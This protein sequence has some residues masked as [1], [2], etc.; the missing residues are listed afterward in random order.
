MLKQLVCGL[1]VM[2]LSGAVGLGASQ[3]ASS[4][5]RDPNAPG[6]LNLSK[7][8]P[9]GMEGPDEFERGFIADSALKRLEQVRGF[10]NSFRQLTDD[11]RRGQPSSELLKTANTSRE[12]QTIG[13]HNIPLV[14]EGT[15]LK[16][17]YQLAQVRYEL[18]QL[19]H[20]QGGLTDQDLAA[21][22]SAYV[23]ATRRFQVFWDTRPPTD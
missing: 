21:A 7:R 11:V 12:V 23:R 19:K 9:D 4:V 16:Q 1:L 22:R 18:A 2:A 15:L 6:Y 20:A 10:L 8:H 13:F 5:P 14:I 3:Q 17:E